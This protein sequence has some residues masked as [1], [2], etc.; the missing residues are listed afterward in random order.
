MLGIKCTEKM[1]KAAREYSKNPNKE[2]MHRLLCLVR[3]VGVQTISEYIADLD[4]S[5]AIQR[6]SRKASA[7]LPENIEVTFNN[8][9]QKMIENDEKLMIHLGGLMVSCLE[10]W[11]ALGGTFEELCNICNIS[12]E[13]GRRK[14]K[15]S[16][17]KEFSGLIFI[18]NLDYKNKGD[19]LVTVPEAPFTFCVKEY[20]LDIICNTDF[21]KQAARKAME[22]VFPELWD[23]RVYRYVDE[24]GGEHFV[25]KDGVEINQYNI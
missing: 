11:Q 2:T 8:P 1:Q 14:L 3:M 12:V 20:M 19:F 18:H 17:R 23:S 16:E 13:Q 21:G 10:Q 22:A 6:K 4:E 15:G 7:A 5:R 9:Y 24:D 25:D